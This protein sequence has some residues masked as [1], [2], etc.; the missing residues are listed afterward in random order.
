MSDR[1]ELAKLS[2]EVTTLRRQDGS[3]SP[4]DLVSWAEAHPKSVL[5]SQFDWDNVNAGHQYR[6]LQA[7]GLIKFHVHTV[8]GDPTE[9]IP[10]ISVPS[11]RYGNEGSYLS[12]DVVGGREDYRLEVL[13][14]IKG[15]L[16]SMNDKF[17]S[18]TPELGSVWKAIGKTC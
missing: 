10:V 13:K 11:L 9:I 16:R 12:R 4:A 5:Y 15:K 18:I 1:R 14:E 3:Y 17:S 7:R 2:K 8:G 6:L